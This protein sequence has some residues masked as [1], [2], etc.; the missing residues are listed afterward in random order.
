MRSFGFVSALLLVAGQGQL[1]HAQAVSVQLPRQDIFSVGTVVSVPDR[2]GAYLGGV[3][4]AADSR[5]LYGFGPLRAGSSIGSE[6]SASNLSAHVYIHDF[7]EMDRMLLNSPTG[8]GLAAA[9]RPLDG[10]AGH[11][12]RQLAQQHTQIASSARSSTVQASGGRQPPEAF[13]VGRVVK[14]PVNDSGASR[15]PLATT[16]VADPAMASRYRREATRASHCGQT[17]TASLYL[18]LAKQCE[19]T[20]ADVAQ[21]STPPASSVSKAEAASKSAPRDFSLN[22]RARRESE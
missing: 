13:G 4:R 8:R 5:S 21:A 20:S 11:A 15:P 10:L 1:A 6:R 3:K 18:R 22:Q 2:G 7:D 16:A 12:H 9:D 19:G 14:S 17:E